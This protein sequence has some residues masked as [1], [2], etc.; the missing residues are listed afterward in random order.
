MPDMGMSHVLVRYTMELREQELR[1]AWEHRLDLPRETQRS[2]LSINLTK[3][4]AKM[5]SIVKGW[6]F[7]APAFG[8]GR[9]LQIDAAPYRL[10]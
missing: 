5:P 3:V 9:P 6:L 8:A 10:R 4:L 1:R 7:P 2:L